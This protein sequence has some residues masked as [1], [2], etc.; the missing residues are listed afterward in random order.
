MFNSISNSWT[1][2]SILRKTENHVCVDRNVKSL[3]VAKT[4]TRWRAAGGVCVRKVA[5]N[6]TQKFASSA[7]CLP[8][9]KETNNA[10]VVRLYVWVCFFKRVFTWPSATKTCVNESFQRLLDGKFMNSFRYSL[11]FT[12]VF[13]FACVCVSWSYATISKASVWF[14][15][16][17]CLCV[18]Q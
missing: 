5:G 6:E 10:C 1:F 16:G 15:F 13:E 4:E 11:M 8:C 9:D 17:L 7:F 2:R 3:L 14:S 18:F 12:S